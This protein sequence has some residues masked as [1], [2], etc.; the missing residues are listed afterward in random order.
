MQ[1]V[2]SLNGYVEKKIPNMIYVANQKN[3]V[4]V[5]TP[6]KDNMFLS[7]NAIKFLIRL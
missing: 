7:E 4:D 5:I 1:V 3:Y 6:K 2:K